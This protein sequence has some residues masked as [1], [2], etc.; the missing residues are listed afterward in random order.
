MSEPKRRVFDRK[1]KVS[2]VKRVMAGEIAAALSRELHIS[3]GLISKWCAHFRR[4][5]PYGLRLA[6]RPRNNFGPAALE[7]ASYAKQ[8]DDLAAARA[9]IGELESKVGQQQLE[10]DFFR[11]ALRQVGEAGRPSDGPGVP[12]STLRSPR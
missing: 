9:R 11:E 2:V 3:A 6:G 12:A 10:L 7:A 8:V 1:F 4:K 5:G